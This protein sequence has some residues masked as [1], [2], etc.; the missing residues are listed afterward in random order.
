MPN[1]D[2]TPPP[3]NSRETMNEAISNANLDSGGAGAAPRMDAGR[4]PLDLAS[5]GVNPWIIAIAVMIAT[6]MEVLDTTITNVALP[7][8]AG[9]LSAGVDESTWVLTSY[10]VS[11]AIVLPVS[12]WLA[13]LFGRKRFFMGCVVLFTLSSLACGIATNLEMLILFRVLQ[14]AGGGA[15]QPISQAILLES[16]PPR[17]HGMAMAVFAV[18]VVIAPIVGPTLGGWLT[19]QYSWRWCFYINLP[20][21]LLALLLMQAFIFDPPYLK[22]VK[23]DRI[24]FVG[25]GLLAVGLG[26]L[27]VV[28]D[29]GEREDW[30]ESAWLTKFAVV[31]AATLILFLIWEF[32][33][34]DPVVDLRAL[35]DRNLSMGTLLMFGFGCALYSS[36]VLYPILLQTLLGYT[37]LLSGWAL[38]PGGIAT[39]LFLP[40]A[41][42][43]VGTVDTRL[44]IGIGFTFVS[45]GLFMMAGFNLQVDFAAV[46]WPR[47]VLGLGLAF[48]FVPLATITFSNVPK[49]AMG[50]ATGIYNLM[51]NIGGSVGI[52][53]STTMIAR[54][55]QYHQSVLAGHVTAYNL[56]VSNALDQWNSLLNASGPSAPVVARPSSLGLLYGEVQRQSTMLAIDDV[57]RLLA[58]LA[59]GLILGLF[60]LRKAHGG[61]SEAA[62]H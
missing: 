17:K 39:L 10:L 2:A 55:T 24:D 15:L 6:F 49:A 19:D 26:C 58:M 4:R 59:A 1:R 33:V 18:G 7:H 30:F 29:K 13:G 57:F 61:A 42:R 50:N 14:G 5:G 53:L 27:Q 23:A 45:A 12:G 47:V 62:L 38:S 48:C 46:V 11:N 36:I 3:R 32:R 28:L 34:R 44:L 16:F 21:G 54:R 37:A 52:A 35:R 31:S 9:N 8:I 56:H 20:V 25:L 22:R 40:I 60:F 51:R 43:L 41:G